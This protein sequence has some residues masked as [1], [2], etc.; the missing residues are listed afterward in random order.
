MEQNKKLEY[1]QKRLD[2]KQRELKD[3]KALSNVVFSS[4]VLKDMDIKSVEI[5]GYYVSTSE[6]N[7]SNQKY[8]RIDIELNEKVV[9][10]DKTL[11][12]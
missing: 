2:E 6:Y 11:E 9:Q 12:D 4:G 3:R 7:N 10:Y 1:E 5:T 8:L